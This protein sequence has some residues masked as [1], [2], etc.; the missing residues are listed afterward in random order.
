MT[1]L[2]H[3]GLVPMLASAVDLAV[4]DYAI[5]AIYVVVV[6]VYKIQTHSR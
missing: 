4:V 3:S 1:S 2:L 5:L 6:V